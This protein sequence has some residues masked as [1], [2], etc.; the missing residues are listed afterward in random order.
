M[1]TN[2]KEDAVFDALAQAAAELSDEEVAAEYRE[3]GEELSAV[4]SRVRGLL[5]AAV[6]QHQ[7]RERHRLRRDRASRLNDLGAF[8]SR[9]P[10]AP[11]KRRQ[12]LHVALQRHPA[13][14]AEVTAQFR[15]LNEMTDDDVESA[16]V[17]LAFLGLLDV[18][19]EPE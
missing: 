13:S 18:D 11:E 15:N 9:L 2:K 7:S 4:A 5:S 3:E 17:Q 1:T 8:R 14:A 6:V 16:L 19:E 10:V 12:W